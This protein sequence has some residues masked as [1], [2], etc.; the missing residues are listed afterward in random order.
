MLSFLAILICYLVGSFPTGVVISKR[1][2]GLDVR[3]VGSGNIGATNIT[4]VFGWYAGFLTF[5]IDFL[6]GAVPLWLM[7]LFFSEAPWVV[8]AGGICLVVGHCYSLFLGFKGGKGVATSLGCLMVTLPVCAL[9]YGL[10]YLVLLKLSRI[11]AVGSLGG[12]VAAIIY[13][14]LRWPGIAPGSLVLM[15]CIIVLIRHQENIQRLIETLKSRR[16]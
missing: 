15:L 16:S 4:R 6:K 10:V 5:L 9:I 3:E 7:Q 14:I 8:T 13:L 11:S 12:V 1:K 2:Y